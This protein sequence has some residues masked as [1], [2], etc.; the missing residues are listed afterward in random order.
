MTREQGIA[1]WKQGAQDAIEAA[2]LLL[3]GGKHALAL[4]HCHLAAEKILKAE[5][6]REKDKAPPKT[7][8]LLSIALELARPWTEEEQKKLTD[9]TNFA[10]AARYDDLEWGSE[11]EAI[12]N[13][14]WWITEVKRIHFLYEA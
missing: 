14:Q 13:V 1:H 10:V 2:E 4:F 7:H 8:D 12:E 3:R 11:Q 5:Y 9:L 6:I